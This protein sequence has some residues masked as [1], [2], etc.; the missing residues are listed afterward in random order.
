MPDQVMNF[1]AGSPLTRL[2]MI[3]VLCLAVVGAW[4][5]IRAYAGNTVAEYLAGDDGGIDTSK[6]AV[7]LAPRDPYAHWRLGTILQRR[8]PADQIGIA[9]AE[10]EKAVSLS[11]NDYRYWM[12]LGTALESA[13]DSEKGERALRRAL[14]LAPSYAYPHWYLGN[15]LLRTGRYPE[16]FEELRRAS[17]S[18]ETFRP[19]LFNSAYGVYKDD[20]ETLKSAVGN[21]PA[22][23]AGFAHYL[24]GLKKYDDGVMLWKTLSEKDRRINREE[25]EAVVAALIEAKHYHQAAD[26][27]NDLVSGPAYAAVKGKFIDGTFEDNTAHQTGADFGWEVTS[28]QQAQVGIDPSAG[29]ESQ[30]SLR[31]LFQV[32][33]KLDV[34]D[35]SQLVVIEPNTQYDLEFYIKTQKIDGADTPEVAIVDAADGTA[36]GRSTAA[37][38]GTSDWQR[39]TLNFKAGAKTEAVI[40]KFI[41]A[42]CGADDLCPIFGTVWYDDFTLK[43]RA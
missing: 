32:R 22:M 7:L 19:Q 18:E 11:P 13:G 4:F 35:V 25:G 43:P 6:R 24:I 33:S 26:I 28:S 39:V 34:I 8:L 9:L 15:L 31:I 36:L 42:T 10:Y 14:E 29:H 17:E 1:D 37:P 30:R 3:L 16:A 23:R 2:G 20:T 12:D 40:L 27:S 38:T 5:A 21:D 41:R